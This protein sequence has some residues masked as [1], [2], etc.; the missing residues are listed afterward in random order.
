M[1]K[2]NPG[3]NKGMKENLMPTDKTERYFDFFS[4]ILLVIYFFSSEHDLV[5]FF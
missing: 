2:L 1:I 4:D 3:F 5:F